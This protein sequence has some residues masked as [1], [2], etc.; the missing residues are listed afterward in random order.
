M[1][2]LFY[3]KW[4]KI[5]GSWNE[6]TAKQAINILT[7]LS[8]GLP[9]EKEKLMLL[10]ILLKWSWWKTAVFFGQFRFN[11]L[12]K[13]KKPSALFGRVMDRTAT[14]AMAMDE[15]TAFLKAENTLT[16]NLLPNYKKYAG[17]S[18]GMDNLRMAE[19]V[20]A[21]SYFFKWRDGKNMGDL[22][23]LVATI[24]RPMA[25]K[26]AQHSDDVRVNFNP[27]MIAKYAVVVDRWPWQVKLLIAQYYAASRQ[28]KIAQNPEVFADS[29]TEEGSAFGLWGVMR[30]VAK[31][32]HFG[33][34]DKVQELYVDTVLMELTAAILEAEKHE[35]EMESIK[36]N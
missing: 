21:E 11:N 2:E 16:K 23:N 28:Q 12:N 8:I 36:N 5:A 9:I 34:F 15:L 26:T 33:D 14:L 4:W 19:F 7:V 32:G 3:K 29:G 22:N 17:P 18:D 10:K 25:K 1:T 6:L 24:Y 13:I 27:N 31:A 30:S 20:Y 35:Q